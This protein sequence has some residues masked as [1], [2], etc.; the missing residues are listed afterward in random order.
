IVGYIFKNEGKD[1]PLEVA[2]KLRITGNVVFT[3]ERSDI[4]ELL[5]VMDI[6][7]LSSL[8]EGF[9]NTILESMAAG[10]PVV[11]TNVGGNPEVV[12]DNETG[13]LVPPAN[14]Q[15][16]AKAMLY[17]LKNKELAQKMGE[18]GRKRIEEFFSLKRMTE[19]TEKLYDVLL[20]R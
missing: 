6:S 2:K 17:L 16:L 3:G 14:S 15:M 9:S 20:S 10:K 7:V 8:S 4:P 12:S 19:N 11:A 13:I 5:S 18:A 1:T